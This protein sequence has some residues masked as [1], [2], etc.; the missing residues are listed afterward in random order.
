MKIFEYRRDGDRYILHCDGRP[1]GPPLQ[2]FSLA[3]DRDAGVLHKHGA[4]ESVAAWAEQAQR[5]L[6]AAGF[7]SM[8]DDLVILT[9]AFPTKELNRCL[10]DSSYAGTYIRRLLADP[11]EACAHGAPAEALCSPG[12]RPR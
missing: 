12:P 5:R 7:G 10:D 11:G 3:I 9:G 2:E 1:I 6:R 8:A 4:P